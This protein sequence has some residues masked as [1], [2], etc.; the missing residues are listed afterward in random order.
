MQKVLLTLVV[1]FSVSWS[2]DVESSTLYYGSAV[3]A[4]QWALL[5]TTD[6]SALDSVYKYGNDTR[7]YVMIRGW[8]VQE[9]SG[10]QSILSST[11]PNGTT[12]K[13]LQGQQQFLERAIRR[14]DLE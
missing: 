3:E 2:K 8:L 14:I 10:V 4:V 11:S 6:P 13:K 9:L 7:L 1:L 5:N 12:T